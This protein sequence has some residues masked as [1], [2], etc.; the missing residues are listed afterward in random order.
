MRQTQGSSRKR[1]LSLLTKGNK[2]TEGTRENSGGNDNG[3][4]TTLD[5]NNGPD[6]PP[7]ARGTSRCERL[8]PLGEEYE[9]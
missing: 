4:D 7:W 6:E 3:R 1:S 9:I 8:R 2:L 5:Q